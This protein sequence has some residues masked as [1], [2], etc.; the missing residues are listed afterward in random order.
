[1]TLARHTIWIR[2]SPAEVFD[3]FT[4]FS[5]APRW[6]QYVESMTPATEGPLAAGSRVNVVMRIG[7]VAH[8]FVLHVL[9]CER[10]TTWRHHTDETHFRGHIEYRFAPENDGTRVTMTID[11]RPR[12]L[13]GWL[14]MPIAL[15]QRPKP[16]AQQLPQ[17]KRALEEA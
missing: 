5:Q 14:A 2:R 12:G 13:Y 16:Y 1:M 17:L 9:A 7:G 10:P 8:R 6:R 3:F 15:L 11:A 4:D